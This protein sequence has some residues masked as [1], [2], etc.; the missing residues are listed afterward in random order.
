MDMNL[1]SSFMAILKKCKSLF[2]ENLI[3]ILSNILA[4]D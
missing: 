2:L 4:E 3:Y 1:S